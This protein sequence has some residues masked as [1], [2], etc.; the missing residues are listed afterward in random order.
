M[1]RL[2]STRL[3]LLA[4]VSPSILLV[5]PAS[6]VSCSLLWGVREAVANGTDH[7]LADGRAFLLRRALL[8][9]VFHLIRIISSFAVE[10]LRRF[11]AFPST[12]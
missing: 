1:F 10:R 5:V 8:L 12:Q 11:P 9:T 7:A 4:S 2:V 6:C 3:M